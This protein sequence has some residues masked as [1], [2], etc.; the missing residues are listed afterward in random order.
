[1]HFALAADDGQ[2]GLPQDSFGVIRKCAFLNM[3]VE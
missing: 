2:T 3:D 1:M